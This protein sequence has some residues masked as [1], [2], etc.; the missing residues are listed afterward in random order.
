MDR[1]RCAAFASHSLP[2]PTKYDGRIEYDKGMGK[3]VVVG[4]HSR[5]IGKTSVVA[6]LIRALQEFGWVAMKITQYGHGICSINGESC[7][8]SNEE[9]RYA[10]Q[11]EADRSG[12]SD[13]S[14]F[15]VA[16]AR[17]SYWVRTKQGMLDEAMPRVNRLIQE[18]SFVILESNSVLGYIRPDLYLV[19]LDFSVDDFKDST[20]LYIEKADAF[21]VLNQGMSRNWD[22]IRTDILSEKPQFPVSPP[23]YISAEVAHF[24]KSRMISE[25]GVRT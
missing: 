2:A 9:H 6:G 8:C 25:G 22:G 20:R 11:K 1:S 15:L 13:S 12:T 17:E 21:I 18:N 3:T 23:E 24:V 14:R 16:G 5:N 7:H 10:V 4:G 19:V